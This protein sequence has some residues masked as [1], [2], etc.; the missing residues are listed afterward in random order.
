MCADFPMF[1]SK[2]PSWKE[3]VLV[4]PDIMNEIL[5][6]SK[7]RRQE[8]SRFHIE[9]LSKDDVDELSVVSILKCLR[10]KGVGVDGTRETLVKRLESTFT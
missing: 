9:S 1:A 10:A 4:N 2:S 3:S 6:H 5:V 7:H 8:V